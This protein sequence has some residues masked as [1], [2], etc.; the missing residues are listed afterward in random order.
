MRGAAKTLGDG[1]DADQVSARFLRLTSDLRFDLFAVIFA[2]GTLHHELQFIIEQQATGPVSEYMERWARVK[3]S[4]GW[5]S[6]VGLALHLADL[7]ISTLILVLPWRRALMCTLAPT[8]LVSQL[9]SLERIP[10]HNGLMAGGLAIVLILGTAELVERALRRDRHALSTDWLGWTVT[11]LTWICGLTY[12]F[13]AFHKLNQGWFS[14]EIS[15][16]AVFLLRPIKVLSALLSNPLDSIKAFL[17]PLGMYGTIA[18]EALIPILLA[19]RKTRL[20]GCFVGLALFHLPMLADGFGGFPTLILAFYPLFLS[21][22]QVRDLMARCLKPTR[23]R[24]WC[25][26]VL[27]GVG[28]VAIWTS[29]FV[30]D[31]HSSAPGAEPYILLT[32]MVLLWLTVIFFTYVALTLGERLLERRSRQDQNQVLTPVPA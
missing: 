22:E 19:L 11:G 1:Q 12:A 27:G 5:S 18:I 20:L 29:E 28:V 7:V 6:E 23:W 4:I 21:A 26:V 32:R 30:H 9:A 17:V 14:P 13:A 3:P 2:L 24:L 10:A 25:T 31:L 15:P 16:A 8:W